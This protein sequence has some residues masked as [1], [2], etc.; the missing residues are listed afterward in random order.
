M[1]G[2]E[3]NQT[4]SQKIPVKKIPETMLEKKEFYPDPG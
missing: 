4:G 3:K 1:P 2:C